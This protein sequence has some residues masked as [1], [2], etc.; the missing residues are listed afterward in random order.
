M[1]DPLNLTLT[2][3]DRIEPTRSCGFGEI[4]AERIKGWCLGAAAATLSL[5]RCRGGRLA[6]DTHHFV[7]HLIEA[8]P[9]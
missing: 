7:A 3:Y 4:N 2:S 6:E 9:E 1:N 5:R 8:D